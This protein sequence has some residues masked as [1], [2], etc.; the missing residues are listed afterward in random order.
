MQVM[1]TNTHL[2]Q[3]SRDR[4]QLDFLFKNVHKY[5]KDSNNTTWKI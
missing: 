3:L 5:K 4:K 2:A 1:K